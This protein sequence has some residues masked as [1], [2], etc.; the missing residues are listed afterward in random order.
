MGGATTTWCCSR[1]WDA[2]C[3]RGIEASS[4]LGVALFSHSICHVTQEVEEHDPGTWVEI[5][6]KWSVPGQVKT[7]LTKL[8]H[9]SQPTSTFLPCAVWIPWHHSSHVRQVPFHLKNLQAR[10]VSYGFLVTWLA[11]CQAGVPAQ[12]SGTRDCHSEC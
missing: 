7:V 5:H 1:S 12:A 3:S 9:Q 11:K 2:G 4:A 8:I 10:R 6:G